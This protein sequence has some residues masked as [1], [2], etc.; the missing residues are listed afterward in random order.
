MAGGVVF[1]HSTKLWNCSICGVNASG[2]SSMMMSESTTPSIA[3]FAFGSSLQA[4]G[5][6]IVAFE[7]YMLA[8]QS[9]SVCSKFRFNLYW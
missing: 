6:K 7:D 5:R 2:A 9:A 3:F 1:L 4:R 8:H